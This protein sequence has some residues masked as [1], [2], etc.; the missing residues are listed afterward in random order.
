MFDRTN[1]VA[2]VAVD[3]NTAVITHENDSGLIARLV[4]IHSVY[5]VT[6]TSHPVWQ[7]FIRETC[8]WTG[9]RPP[10]RQIRLIQFRPRSINL[11]VEGSGGGGGW[12]HRCPGTAVY[13][14]M[15]CSTKQLFKGHVFAGRGE[16]GLQSVYVNLSQTSNSTVIYAENLRGVSSDAGQQ[17]NTAA[18]RLPGAIC[19]IWENFEVVGNDVE[20]LYCFK[21]CT[22]HVPSHSSFTVN[23]CVF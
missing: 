1:E 20:T 14:R 23:L 12:R 18:P 17:W 11:V 2:T 19:G 7:Q 9:A 21:C 22:E 10:A 6:K 4:H 16:H 15:Y 13:A 8:V 3:G 5:T